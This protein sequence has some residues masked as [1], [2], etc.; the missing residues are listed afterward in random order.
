MFEIEKQKAMSKHFN[1][2]SIPTNRTKSDRG[3]DEIGMFEARLD[4][5]SSISTILKGLWKICALCNLRSVIID[6]G[7]KVDNKGVYEMVKP[8]SNI[9]S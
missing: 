3:Y 7:E 4:H 9:S 1:P 2:C 6:N 5:L 8:N